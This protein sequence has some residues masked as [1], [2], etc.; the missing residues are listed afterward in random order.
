[1]DSTNLK[2]FDFYSLDEEEERKKAV[3]DKLFKHEKFKKM[4]FKSL[5][6]A[7][8]STLIIGTG[9]GFYQHH[10]TQINHQLAQA[11]LTIK[12]TPS[13]KIVDLIQKE[14]E[15][16]NTTY[17]KNE[18]L[19]N[20]YADF[21][22]LVEIMH[23]NGQLANKVKNNDS[24]KSESLAL[25]EKDKQTI[26]TIE[27][28]LN[29]SRDVKVSTL[30]ENGNL[31]KYNQWAQNV[32][33]N[34]FMYIGGLMQ[35]NHDILKDLDFL[36][37]TKNDIIADVNEKIKSKDYNLDEAQKS[38]IENVKQ[39]TDSQIQDLKKAR[40]EVA[41]TANDSILTDKDVNDAQ[42]AMN[43]L[44]NVAI[45]KVKS[46]R[47]TIEDLINKAQS[48]Q[49]VVSQNSNSITPTTIVVNQSSQDHGL[50]FFDYY[51]LSHWLNSGSSSHYDSYNAG[52]NA[53]VANS[54]HNIV[55]QG[56]LD[57]IYKSQSGLYS[58]KN[59]NSYLN[60]SLND[61]SRG[62]SN[63]SSIAQKS[64]TTSINQVNKVK[65]ITSL[66]SEVKKLDLTALRAK[67]EQAKTKVSQVSHIQDARISKQN[68]NKNS[69]ISSL[70]SKKSTSSSLWKSTSNS[71]K[72]FSSTSRRRK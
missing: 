47:A 3:K 27:Q 4:G 62:F 24:L 70:N 67:M 25:L 50:T 14:E 29:S 65:N 51:L 66:Q 49:S 11:E 36:Q 58:L 42:S 12:S 40:Q 10:Q 53:G 44:Q 22:E 68:I 39:D 59:D 34:Q 48:N 72:G 38:I 54:Y 63:T 7:T 52:Y 28:A 61:S 37:S 6:I 13:N 35:L 57:T 46:D 1:M 32:K 16:I 30:L 23:M 15:A 64:S 71:N 2:K 9:V 8:A 56:R 21:K 45:D 43:D 33:T 5:A 60:K 26:H 41:G 18:L 19:F 20:K 31:S 69:G 55:N 17:A